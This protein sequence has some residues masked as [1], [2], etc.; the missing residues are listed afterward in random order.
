MKSSDLFDLENS[1]LKEFF[2][3][4]NTLHEIISNI[5]DFLLFLGEKL[6]DNYY[7]LKENVWV[8]KSA[9]IGSGVE[10]IGPAIIMENVTIRH[11]AFLRENVFVGKNSVIGNSC[12]IKNSILI[13]YCEVPHF[14]YVGDSI[15]G[16]YVHFGAGVIVSN[17]RLDKKN[18]RINGEDTNLQKVG[19]FIGDN[20]QIGANCVVAPGTIIYPETIIYPLL[21]VKGIV[22]DKVIKDNN[23]EK[24]W[25]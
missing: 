20:V 3:K 13:G 8:H 9:L 6:D 14:N 2:M 18:I 21:M 1:N 17:L 19:A 4:F 23:Y 11:N 7:M 5:H 15:L 25:L 24:K 22:K 16:N 10:I 12:E